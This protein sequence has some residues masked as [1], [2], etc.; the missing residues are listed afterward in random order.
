[1]LKDL[2]KSVSSEGAMVRMADASY[3]APFRS[4]IEYSAPARGAWNIVHTGMLLPEAHQIFV[5]AAG[6]LRG[7]VLTAA[8]MNAQDRFST[9]AVREENVLEGDMEDLILEGVADILARLPKRPPAVLLYTS[10]IHHF[11][12]CDLDLVYDRLRE[13]FPDVDFTDCYMNPIMRKSGLTP[14]QLMRRQLY[15]LIR[16]GQPK[17]PKK[18][19]I[20]GNNPRM[21]ADGDLVRMLRGAGWT[22]QDIYDMST[23]AAYQTM[24]T[25]AWNISWNPAAKPAGDMMEQKLGQQHLY[26][27]NS[28]G[29]EEI[30]TAIDEAASRCGVAALDHEAEIAACEEEIAKAKETVG[31]TTVWIDYTATNRPLSLA[32]LLLTH[33]F[34][35]DT[36]FLDSVSGVEKN[37]FDWLKEHAPNLKLMATVHP[38]MRLLPR[39]QKEK[40]LAIG[41]KAAYFADTPYFVNIVEDDGQYGYTGIRAM[42]GQMIESMEN[43]KDT[44]ALIQIKG[45]GCGVCV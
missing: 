27:P 1:M 11:I 29:Y 17:D 15:S 39:E 28:Y 10:C 24:G 12:G 13:R 2:H 3:P 16:P 45:L 7:V 23:Y 38:K 41:Q 22:V 35:V 9:I 37:D 33:G 44:R 8:E 4:G 21:A 6:C 25:A 18:V 19:N 14:D 31:T 40:I 43:E 36:V 34:H 30:R 42:M 26:L 5:C 32:R 20:I